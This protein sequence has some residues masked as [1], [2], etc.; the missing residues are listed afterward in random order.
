[1]RKAME[2][3]LRDSKRQKMKVRKLV[4][5]LGEQDQFREVEKAN[6]EADIVRESKEAPFKCSKRSVALLPAAEGT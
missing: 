5:L 1:M 3:A 2:G 4:A 6:I